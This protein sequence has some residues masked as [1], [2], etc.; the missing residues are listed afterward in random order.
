MQ[1]DPYTG[2][3]RCCEQHCARWYRYRGPCY[4]HRRSP[5]KP[6]ADAASQALRANLVSQ[7]NNVIA[8]ITTTAQDASFNGINLLNAMTSS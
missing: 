4:S 7:Y 2:S 1:P 3:G 5:G 6:L 8:Q